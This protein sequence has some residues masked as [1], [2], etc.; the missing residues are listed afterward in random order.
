MKESRVM[1]IIGIVW[2]LA[3]MGE[4]AV[5]SKTLHL[6]D[7]LPQVGLQGPPHTGTNL[8]LSLLCT[9]LGTPASMVTG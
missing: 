7:P 8:S 6:M 4:D 1:A 5:T 9:L 3:G 2:L